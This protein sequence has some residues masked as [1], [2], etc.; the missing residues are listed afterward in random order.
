MYKSDGGGAP[1]Y[2]R[3]IIRDPVF[4]FIAEKK[5]TKLLYSWG[6]IKYVTPNLYGLYIL[7]IYIYT[8]FTSILL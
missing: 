6:R 8:K 5:M 1:P 7:Y 2:N 4:R 3:P